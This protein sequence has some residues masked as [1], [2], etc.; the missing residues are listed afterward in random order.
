MTMNAAD[1][2]ALILGRAI[3][4]A[5]NLADDLAAAKAKLLA[6]DPDSKEGDPPTRA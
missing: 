4:R 6:I 1:R 3:I 5:E 2:V